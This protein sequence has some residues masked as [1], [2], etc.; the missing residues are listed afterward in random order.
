VTSGKNPVFLRIGRYG[1]TVD[2]LTTIGNNYHRD[3]A[4]AAFAADDAAYGVSSLIFHSTGEIRMGTGA[5]GS[6]SPTNHFF[7]DTNGNGRVTGTWGS[8][9]IIAGGHL[10]TT[11][12][13]LI[14]TL[15][16]LRDA[17]KDETTLEGLRDAIGNAISTLVSDLQSKDSDASELMNEIIAN[18]STPE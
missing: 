6:A 2:G 13:D 14:T 16:A 1:N 8:N 12:D 9:K 15:N 10:V 3:G 18:T 4:G 5:A 17:T 11:A 7:L